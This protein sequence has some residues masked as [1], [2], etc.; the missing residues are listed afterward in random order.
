VAQ[1]L[2]GLL[3][4]LAAVGLVLARLAHLL[5]AA[6][7]LTAGLVNVVLAHVVEIA[8][9]LAAAAVRGALGRLREQVFALARHARQD[10]A[11]HGEEDEARG[12]QAEALGTSLQLGGSFSVGKWVSGRIS[13]RRGAGKRNGSA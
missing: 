7:G 13:S 11:E 2:A 8:G 9:G 10:A 5:A 12:D 6:L 3:H 1:A 4:L